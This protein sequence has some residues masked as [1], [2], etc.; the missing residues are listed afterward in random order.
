MP[1]CL[2]DP[3]YWNS[4]PVGF[5]EMVKRSL[6]ITPNGK[7]GKARNL[8]K[9]FIVKPRECKSCKLSKRCFWPWK[10]YKEIFGL[11]ELKPI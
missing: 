6:S 9:E 11:Q 4:C 7:L 10:G 5:G 2:I 8:L 1:M 3:S